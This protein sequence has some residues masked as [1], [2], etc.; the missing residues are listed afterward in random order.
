MFWG[1]SAAV[2]YTWI[3]YPVALKIV[4][5]LHKPKGH[6]QPPGCMP[7]VSV[8]LVVH[9]E[10]AV[11]EDALTDLLAMEY[12]G[13]LVEFIVVSDGSTDRTNEIVSCFAAS[14]PR[15]KLLPAARVGLT[16]GITLGVAEAK[17]EVIVRTDAD[18]RH[19]RN[20]LMKH[21]LHYR[22]PKVGAVGGCFSF[23]NTGHTSIT[24]S[25]G[26]YW[27]FEMFLR[28][29][30]SD[31]GILSTTSGAVMSFRRCLFEPLAP[32]HSD[33]IV[34]PKL[35]VK[36]GYR[37][38]QEPEA[39]AFEVMP[40]SIEGEFGARRR[41]VSRGFSGIFSEEGSLSL[42]ANPGHWVGMVSHKLMRWC[43]PI[44]LLGS[45]AG[46]LFL[47]PRPIYRL[48]AVAHA[49]LY[50][51]AL[52]GFMLERRKLRLR[53]LSAAFSF[54]LANTGFLFG[55]KD[56]LSGRRVSAFRSQE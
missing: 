16:G 51:S 55:I 18:T 36:K 25:E 17:N 12:P 32:T 27:K 10:E 24:R 6:V 4:G 40:Q 29:A 13:H 22:D 35:V 20:Y 46:S 21:A 48:A 39:V 42:L 7:S 50:V 23:R 30:E 52:A 2:G 37:M 31:A 47:L 38:V 43:T 53:L 3:G 9:N 45:F 49:S 34:I 54:C 11:I 5:K 33:D 28:K 19:N 56:A 8:L 44:F 1:C 26:M 14:D 15:I 41:M